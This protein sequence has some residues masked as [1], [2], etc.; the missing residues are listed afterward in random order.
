MG[1]GSGV[2]R[3]TST[4]LLRLVRSSRAMTEGGWTVQ[5]SRPCGRQLIEIL[6]EQ[7]VHVIDSA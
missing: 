2:L 7:S 5:I 4:V 1:N 6:K 3:S